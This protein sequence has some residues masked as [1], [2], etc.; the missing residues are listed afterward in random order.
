[1]IT[2]SCDEEGNVGILFNDIGVDFGKHDGVWPSDLPFYMPVYTDGKVSSAYT[3]A[4]GTVNVTIVNTSKAAFENYIE[5]LVQD[6]WDLS[7]REPLIASLFKGDNYHVGLFLGDD[8]TTLDIN[9]M[10]FE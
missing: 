4:S 10:A 9:I 2:V 7:D 1:M 5:I 8:E 6:G 3:S